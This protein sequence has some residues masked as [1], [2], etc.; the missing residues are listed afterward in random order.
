MRTPHK[1]ALIGLLALLGAAL[2]GLTLTSE[3]PQFVLRGRRAQSATA[4]Q[5]PIV[6]QQPLET[7]RRLALLAVTPE[8]KELAG[9][10]VR[11]ADHEVD[12]AFTSTLRTAQAQPTRETPATRAIEG[13]IRRGQAEIEGDESKVKQLTELA[14]H[15]KESDQDNLRRQLE[16][17][18][19]ELDLDKDELDDAQEDLARAGGDAHSKLQRLLDEHEAA[20]HAGEASPSNAGPGP[21]PETSLAS[22]HVL[23]QW[24]AWSAFRAKQMDLLQAQQDALS[25]AATLARSHDSLEQRIQQEKPQKL[26]L[27]HQAASL[28]K[29]G[30]PEPETNP[31]EAAATALATVRRLSEDTK[32]LADLDKRIQDLQDLSVIYDQWVSLIQTRQRASLHGL[33]KSALWIILTFLLVFLVDGLIERF[34]TRVDLERK[35]LLTIR[36][37]VRFGVQALGVLVVIFVIFGAPNQ[38][39]TILGLAGAGL[40]VALKDIIV[41]FVGWFVLMGRNGIRVGD[42]V[43]IKG[44]GGVVVEIGL[45]RTV[46]LETGNWT[47]AGHPTGR[48]VAFVNSF[49]VEGHYFN[50]STSGQWLWDE[51][52]V[53]IPE[54]EDPYPITEKIQAIVAAETE[55]NAEEAEAEWQRVTRRYRV[56]S[57]SATPSITMRPTQY[58]VEVI[59]WYITRA[60]ERQI[61]RA[62]LNHAVVEFIHSKNGTAPAVEILPA[63][64]EAG[65][66][67]GDSA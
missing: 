50:F 26:A 41:S 61:A 56:R 53:L 67:E 1:L 51:L 47:E 55:K 11:V 32:S 17:A 23:D 58:G 19:A 40:T 2:L 57:F 31:K 65:P 49:A 54:G 9:D 21:S 35:H 27:T 13:R 64:A 20:Q 28:L 66:G 42:W 8:E 43:E 63:P 14:A 24:R 18:Q 36:A 4:G 52:H 6:D 34:F 60:H 59:V 39:P 7:A 45:L 22:G 38:M 15:A 16:L 12:L 46:L 30:H 3:S 5:G 33:I 37:V 25:A 48:R 10:A 44:V 29:A 62:R